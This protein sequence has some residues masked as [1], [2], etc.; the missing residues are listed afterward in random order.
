[1]QLLKIE[2]TLYQEVNSFSMIFIA[3]ELNGYNVQLNVGCTGN[4]LHYKS[5]KTLAECMVICDDSP[6]CDYVTYCDKGWC[7]GICVTFSGSCKND[8]NDEYVYERRGL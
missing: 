7:A 1:M 8:D 3:D 6:E 2:V 4:F 5:E